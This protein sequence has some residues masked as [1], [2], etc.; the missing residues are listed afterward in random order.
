MGNTGSKGLKKKTPNKKISRFI[1]H[2]NI[3]SKEQKLFEAL[4]ENNLE[5]I[6]TLIKNGAKI[7]ENSCTVQVPYKIGVYHGSQYKC[8]PLHYA[9]NKG[10]TEIVK[11]LIEQ[12]DTNLECESDPIQTTPLFEAIKNDNYK[13]AKILVNKGANVNVNERMKR[14]TSALE[15]AI[16]NDNLEMVELLFIN[17]VDYTIENT[18]GN[19]ALQE[20]I[21]GNTDMLKLFYFLGVDL[22][23]KNILNTTVFNSSTF[24][25]KFSLQYNSNNIAESIEKL[26]NFSID[27]SK[28]TISQKIEFL[29]FLLFLILSIYFIILLF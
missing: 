17:N 19:L 3:N 12:K 29:G 25:Y 8:T 23:K 16:G 5:K 21:N 13:I 11:F 27:L 28:Y 10:Y 14:G 4:K 26:N 15:L 22:N 6:K 2:P 7:N 1:V 20:K 18:N 24:N 9:T